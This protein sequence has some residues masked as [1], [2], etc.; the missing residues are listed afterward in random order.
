[1]EIASESVT[2]CQKEKDFRMWGPR[3][4]WALAPRGETISLALFP[5]KKKKKKSLWLCLF[6]R[7][8]VL[9]S[10]IYSLQAS[11]DFCPKPWVH[12]HPSLGLRAEPPRRPHKWGKQRKLR[13]L[14]C[15]PK[16]PT[17][18]HAYVIFFVT[19]FF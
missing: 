8:V 18:S 1:M 7:L 9:Q 11:F 13:A 17:N 3:R 15:R 19:D 4:N 5:Q 12:D 16:T 2:H 14:I 6:L 10:T